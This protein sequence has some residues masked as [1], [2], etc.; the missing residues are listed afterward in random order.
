MLYDKASKGELCELR[1]RGQSELRE[2]LAHRIHAAVGATICGLRGSHTYRQVRSGKRQKANG[3]LGK[4]AHTEA[5]TRRGCILYFS[6]ELDFLLVRETLSFA[7]AAA[8]CRQERG[9]RARPTFHSPPARRGPP[10]LRKVLPHRLDV[11]S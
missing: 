1:Q 5:K 8:I 3:I 4:Q 7:S 6:K 9:F 11:K 2:P 10:T